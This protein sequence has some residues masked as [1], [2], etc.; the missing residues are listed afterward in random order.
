MPSAGV[1]EERE[2][3]DSLL[4]VFDNVQA[5]LS[6][7][8]VRSIPH[9]IEAF[10]HENG[11]PGK[12]HEDISNACLR[13]M[14]HGSFLDILTA[15]E[16]L[17]KHLQQQDAAVSFQQVAGADEVALSIAFHDHCADVASHEVIGTDVIEDCPELGTSGEDAFCSANETTLL[18]NVVADGGACNEFCPTSLQHTFDQVETAAAVDGG[19]SGGVLDKDAQVIPLLLHSEMHYSLLDIMQGAVPVKCKGTPMR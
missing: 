9:S 12:L 1:R 18:V 13:Y 2:K 14:I 11:V 17:Q 3:N 8:V 15:R 16:I 4:E 19:G 6:D 10:F 7:Q 5:F